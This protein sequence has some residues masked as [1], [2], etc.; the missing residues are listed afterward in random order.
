LTHVNIARRGVLRGILGVVA[1]AVPVM[2]TESDAAGKGGGKK[3]GG[4]GKS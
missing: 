4:D 1:L 3:G 2:T